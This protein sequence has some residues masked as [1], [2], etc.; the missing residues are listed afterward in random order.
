MVRGRT[1]SRRRGEILQT[2]RG[3]EAS[4]RGPTE[5][6][7]TQHIEAGHIQHQKYKALHGLAFFGIPLLSES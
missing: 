6:R 4:E 7:Q 5:P 3:E 2:R 1:N